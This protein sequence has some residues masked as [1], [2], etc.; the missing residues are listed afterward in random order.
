[1]VVVCD[2]SLA[3]QLLCGV[4]EC[5]HATDVRDGLDCVSTRGQQ[6]VCGDVMA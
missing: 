6:H 1:M 3:E 5:V 2:W 4:S